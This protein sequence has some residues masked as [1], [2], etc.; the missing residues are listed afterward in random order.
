VTV[1]IP[2]KI[3]EFQKAHIMN[4]AIAVAQGGE[5]IYASGFGIADH[6]TNQLCTKDTQFFIASI[7]KQFTAAALLHVLWHKNPSIESLKAALYT[8]LSHYL[9]A[10]G[11]HMD[12]ICS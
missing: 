4:G 12:R 1:L 11:F 2:R 7:T 9:P 3:Q 8:P 10:N 6:L 5:T